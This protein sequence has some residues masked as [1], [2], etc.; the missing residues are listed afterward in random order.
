VIRAARHEP[1]SED[2]FPVEL[3]I[4]SQQLDSVHDR[5]I[6]ERVGVLLSTRVLELG[7]GGQAIG[8]RDASVD[9]RPKDD[10]VRIAARGHAEVVVQEFVAGAVVDLERGA[11][12][13]D[14]VVEGPA[15]RGFGGGDRHGPAR[16]VSSPSGRQLSET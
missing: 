6:Q 8:E 13:D 14:R 9:Q 10:D 2:V 1:A 16:A 11:F 3:E 7:A 15:G 5:R 4:G 12:G